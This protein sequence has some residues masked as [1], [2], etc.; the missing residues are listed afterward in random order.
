MI[1]RLA[2]VKTTVEPHVI[3]KSDMNNSKFR[4]KKILK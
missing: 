1:Y 3:T 2:N 4:L